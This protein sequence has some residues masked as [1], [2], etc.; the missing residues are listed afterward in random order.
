LRPFLL[1]QIS[2]Y[3]GTEACQYGRKEKIDAVEAVEACGEF[4]DHGMPHWRTVAYSRP[5]RHYGAWRVPI[6]EDSF[7]AS[8]EPD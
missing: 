8:V 6:D 2:G 5:W 4:G 3:I 7:A 1:S